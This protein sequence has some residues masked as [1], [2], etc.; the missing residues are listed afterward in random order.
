M[1]DLKTYSRE[2]RDADLRLLANMLECA[3]MYLELETDMHKFAAQLIHRGRYVYPGFRWLYEGQEQSGAYIL[4]D[5]DGAMLAT[6]AWR[7]LDSEDLTASIKDFL[8]RYSRHESAGW[9]PEIEGILKLSGKIGYRGGLNSFS[10]I[11]RIAWFVA[12]AALIRLH[13]EGADIQCGEARDE[14]VDTG[15]MRELY[16]YRNTNY[17]GEIDQFGTDPETGETTAKREKLTL[18]WS[19]R[20]EIGEEIRDRAALL[21]QCDPEN[22]RTFLASLYPARKSR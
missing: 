3:G 4:R 14:M 2:E 12:T 10:D 22:L 21:R 18:V 5:G 7:T 8:P 9:A 13:G 19:R 17:L 11:P 6:I 15:L 20:R 16:G 1:R